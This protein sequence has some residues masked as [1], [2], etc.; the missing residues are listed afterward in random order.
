[1]T[2]SWNEVLCPGQNGPISGYL[3][4]FSNSTFSDTVNII[5][6]DNRQY[7]LK[8]LTPNTNYTVMIR[9]YNN[10]GIGPESSEVIQ[11]T[12]ETGKSAN[13][14]VFIIDI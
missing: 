1:M 6:G 4:C 10:G 7:K 2:V 5:G 9:A 8:H 13:I 11:Q 12:G 14:G 3:L